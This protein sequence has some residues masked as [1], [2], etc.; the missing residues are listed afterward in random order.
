MRGSGVPRISRDNFQR[1]TSF[2]HSRI[3]PFKFSSN[4]KHWTKH[5]L[6]NTQTIST[7]SRRYIFTLATRY[8]TQLKEKILFNFNGLKAVRVLFTKKFNLC[9][10]PREYIRFPRSPVVNYFVHTPQNNFLTCCRR[11]V[12]RNGFS[13]V[14]SNLWMRGRKEGTRRFDI[15][16]EIT[17]YYYN[18]CVSF[19]SISKS[20]VRKVFRPIHYKYYVYFMNL[21]IYVYNATTFK[22][23]HFPMR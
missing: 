12:Y 22:N 2:Y 9:R 23:R 10:S 3:V 4:S 19:F 21:T 18:V 11:Y 1:R 20:C 13:S 6:E 16:H 5:D 8:W 15:F 7:R 14:V 17:L